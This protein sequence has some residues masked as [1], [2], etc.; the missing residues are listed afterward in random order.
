MALLGGG[1]GGAGNPVGGSFTGPAQSLELVGDQSGD[2][3]FGYAYSGVIEP[4]AG[5]TTVLDF[6]TGNYLCVGRFEMNADFKGGGGSDY[7]VTIKLNGTTII[8]EQDIANNWLAGDNEFHV[9]IPPYTAVEGLLSDG[10]SNKDMN[11]NFT[12]RVYR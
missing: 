7:G 11:L 8:F 2:H 1:V 4:G 5:P 9:I 3:K 12:A 10:G 6:T